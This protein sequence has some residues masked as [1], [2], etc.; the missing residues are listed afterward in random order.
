MH[1]HAFLYSCSRQGWQAFL[2]AHLNTSLPFLLTGFQT[3]LGDKMPSHMVFIGLGVGDVGKF[4]T[5]ML[6]IISLP[7][8][9]ELCK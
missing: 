3:G 7:D 8:Q 6:R 9:R 2:V 4:E 5:D 1:C